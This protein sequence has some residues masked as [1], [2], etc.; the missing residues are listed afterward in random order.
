[1][2]K[3]TFLNKAMSTV[4]AFVDQDTEYGAK[5]AAASR[6]DFDIHVSCEKL[7]NEESAL[8]KAG[9]LVRQRD[10]KVNAE[11]HG[12]LMLVDTQDA[13]GYAIVGDDREELIKEAHAHLIAD[14]VAID[15]P[16]C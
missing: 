6:K 13:D 4:E 15:A 14:S 2:Y 16:R 12:S 3:I 8:V 5:K 1:M 7:G 9:Y 10:P 11:F